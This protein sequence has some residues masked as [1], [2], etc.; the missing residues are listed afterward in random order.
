MNSLIEEHRQLDK[1]CAGNAVAQQ[2]KL[3]HLG[4]LQSEE[5]QHRKRIRER[6]SLLSDLAQCFSWP[7]HSSCANEPLSTFL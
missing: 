6:D 1:L 2:E 5:E 7:N 3:V 4:K